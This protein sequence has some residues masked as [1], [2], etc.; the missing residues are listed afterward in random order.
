MQ[1]SLNAEPMDVFEGSVVRQAEGGFR[2]HQVLLLEGELM[3]LSRREFHRTVLQKFSTQELDIH[4]VVASC[5][6]DLFPPQLLATQVARLAPGALFYAPICFTG[7]MAFGQESGGGYTEMFHAPVI[8]AYLRHLSEGNKSHFSIAKM[9]QGFEN[10]GLKMLAPAPVDGDGTL[11]G[12]I[13]DADSIW[14][15]TRSNHPSVYKSLLSFLGS[16]MPFLLEAG[17]LRAAAWLSDWVRR[18]NWQGEDHS[19]AF[20]SSITARNIDVLAQLPSVDQQNDVA[21]AKL[22]FVSPFSVEI[23]EPNANDPEMSF[24]A[25]SLKVK[26]LATC[27][28]PGT[29]LR[30]FENRFGSDEVLDEVFN[31]TE[32]FRYPRSYGYQ[33]LGKVTHLGSNVPLSYLH[34]EV[35]AFAPHQ[36]S[37]IVP[38]W[39]SA[40]LLPPREEDDINYEN[41]VFLATMETALSVVQDAEV[42]PGDSVC[43]FGQGLVGNL[44]AAVLG[45]M[46]VRVALVDP[47]QSRLECGAKVLDAVRRG[48]GVRGSAISPLLPPP[49]GVV[50]LQGEEF[51]VCID[52]S[53]SSAALESALERARFGGRLVVGHRIHFWRELAMVL[54][55]G[56]TASHFL[57][58]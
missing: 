49:S 5:F 7:N 14:H 52:L 25:D 53:G 20:P 16:A 41:Y 35:F 43:L 15:V 55:G 51:D 47:A 45:T 36:S 37:V 11:S 23:R 22:T 54:A 40:V 1:L 9:K 34:R 8:N 12:K 50:P 21:P 48:G 13:E 19:A 28:S 42:K 3:D 58:S 56:G 30:L 44:V 6:V 29:E 27:I 4:V 24:T 2:A 31:P 33:L 57:S 18:C 39:R 46:P 26:T 32:I 38:D 10:A 17:E